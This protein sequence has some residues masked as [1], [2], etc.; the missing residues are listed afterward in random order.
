MNRTT[1]TRKP[2]PSTPA[3]AVS[4]VH[5]LREPLAAIRA[6]A[7]MLV[8]TGLS[9][10]EMQRIARNVHGASVRMQELLEEFQD[11]SRSS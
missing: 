8:R 1:N 5:Q 9:L 3:V 11:P 6:G 10:A 7:E 2:E 4:I